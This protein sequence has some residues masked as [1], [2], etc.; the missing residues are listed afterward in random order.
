MNGHGVKRRDREVGK[1]VGGI[2][3]ISVGLG[4][5]YLIPISGYLEIIPFLKFI[6]FLG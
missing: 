4:G 6:S 1:P 5:P 3:G 2:S